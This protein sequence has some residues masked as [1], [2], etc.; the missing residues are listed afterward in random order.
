MW[1]RKFVWHE[2][3]DLYIMRGWICVP[4][5]QHE[6]SNVTK[7]VNFLL[8]SQAL[9]SSDAFNMHSDFTL[10]N[11][12]DSDRRRKPFVSSV[13][14]CASI[15]NVK[16]KFKPIN[17]PWSLQVVWEAV[18]AVTGR[19]VGYALDWL[20]SHDALWFSHYT[21]FTFIWI[22]TQVTLYKSVDNIQHA[23]HADLCYD[24]K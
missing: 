5:Y 1:H 13:L 3:C 16:L 14:L 11:I 21:I 8:L 2:T 9:N 22:L 7:S 18:W 17:F 24:R 10:K 12:S 23:T 20:P 15:K 6:W 19:K 4:L